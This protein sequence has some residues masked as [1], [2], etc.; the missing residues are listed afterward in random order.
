MPR[1][2]NA[3]VRALRAALMWPYR[4]QTIGLKLLP[5]L[6]GSPGAPLI[7]QGTRYVATNGFRPSVV[8]VHRHR[9]RCSCR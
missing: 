8:F 5:C 2:R 3:A 9:H 4:R 7:C 6:P 1:P